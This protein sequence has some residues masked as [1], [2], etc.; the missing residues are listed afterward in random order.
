[1]L[2]QIYEVSTPGEARL[3]SK[4][5]VDHIGILIGNGEFPRELSIEVAA[6]VAV[7]VRP[8]SRVSALFLNCR[9]LSNREKC[10]RTLPGDRPPRGCAGI[11]LP[12]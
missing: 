10:V 6:E 3:I 4:F 2:T 11:A 9:P 12:R 5:G 8:P 1:V 7:A